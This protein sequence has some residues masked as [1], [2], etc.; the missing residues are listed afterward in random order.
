MSSNLLDIF[1]LRMV[2]NYLIIL[3][4]FAG[5]GLV[6]HKLLRFTLKQTLVGLGIVALLFFVAQ[7]FGLVHI[8]LL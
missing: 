3:L 5:M 8:S 6:I 2:L 7:A 4:A 1:W